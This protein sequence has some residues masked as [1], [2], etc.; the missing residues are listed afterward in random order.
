MLSSEFALIEPVSALSSFTLSST[1]TSPVDVFVSSTLF[2]PVT[3]PAT[4]ESLMESSA[5]PT[6]STLPVTIDWFVI[7]SLP[8]LEM[9]P[10]IV[11]PSIVTPV[12]PSAIETSP[13]TTAPLLISSDVAP[14]IV[15]VSA[16][17]RITSPFASILPDSESVRDT[18][19]PLI[20]PST[21]EPVTVTPASASI[22]PVAE[23]STLAV[24]EAVIA[25]EV[26]PP[27]TVTSVPL[28]VPSTVEPVTVAT[29]SAEI[30][31]STVES[32]TEAA[33]VV[34]V[35][36]PELEPFVSVTSAPLIVP[37]C[38]PLRS[39]VPFVLVTLPTVALSR[40]TRPP[41]VIVPSTSEF[42][43]LAESTEVMAPVVEPPVTVTFAPL[44]VPESA[45]VSST[46]PEVAMLPVVES[47]MSTLPDTSLML[48]TV[49][50]AETVTV[51]APV[52]FP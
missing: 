31:P 3:V 8:A 46:S 16:L 34:A 40:S 29:P 10:W 9:L 43:T 20:V 48:P 35:M 37:A 49:E 17:L 1:D 24:P 14:E 15:P 38:E 25:P 30:S 45:F 11:E 42:S 44:I 47:S 5:S 13:F 33:P 12:L 23:F 28:I 41:A 22:E 18:S 36:A 51:S 2:A 32:V 6:S 50:P 26:E 7:S 19:V 4:V 39:T 21:V 52:T 27:V